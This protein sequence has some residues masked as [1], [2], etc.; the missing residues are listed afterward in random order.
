MRQTTESS[1]HIFSP[2]EVMKNLNLRMAGQKFSGYQFA[3]CCYCLLNTKTLQLTFARA[4]HPYPIFIR[5]LQ[6]P[7][8]LETRGSLLGIFDQAEYVQQTVQLQPGDK[9]LL[10]SDGAESFIGSLDEQNVFGFNQQ[11]CEI[12]DLPVL[13]MMDE[14][15]TVF[16]NQKIKPIGIDDIT[17]IGL[18][19]L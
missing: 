9:M 2:A 7:Q 10:Y 4:G 13:E 1:Y 19:I 14:F 5:A 6:P 3:T 11:F 18:E 15:N 17:V 8:Q 12:K 16:Q